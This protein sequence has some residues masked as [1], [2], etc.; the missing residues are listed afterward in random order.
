MVVV[1][2]VLT[3]G[4]EPEPPDVAAGVIG[5]VA[6]ATDAREVHHGVH[7]E[8]AVPQEHGGEEEPPE[9]A[10]DSPDG[11]GGEREAERRKK[12]VPVEPPDFRV[13]LEFSRDFLRRAIVLGTQEPQ[14]VRPPESLNRRRVHVE[15]GVG[16]A[17]VLAVL[18]RPPA[19]SA[20]RGGG[21][22]HCEH[23]LEL[24]RRLKGSVREVAVEAGGDAE[25]PGVVHGDAQ[26]HHTPRAVHQE[27]AENGG[28][29]DGEEWD[30]AAETEL[31]VGRAG[32]TSGAGR[33]GDR[34]SAHGVT[35]QLVVHYNPNA[36]NNKSQLK[37][38][39][40]NPLTNAI[41]GSEAA[42]EARLQRGRANQFQASLIL[43]S[44]ARVDWQLK[45]IK[46]YVRDCYYL[47]S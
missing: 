41:I 4:D 24:P 31:L 23:E 42:A 11:E 40:T 45:Y 18:A 7:R 25:H 47:S 5:L 21:A 13:G 43:Y 29:V 19:R 12:I 10:G 9:E 8:G 15:R 2:P 6:S 16:V 34:E 28:E 44:V 32:Q 3:E 37:N 33:G 30:G 17:V 20:L 39:L 14:H 26:E 22:E 35:S 27:N 1:V 36:E 46:K 38:I